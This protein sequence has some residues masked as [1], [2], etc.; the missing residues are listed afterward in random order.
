MCRRVTNSSDARSRR[1]NHH[2]VQHAD[3]HHDHHETGPCLRCAGPGIDDHDYRAMTTVRFGCLGDRRAIARTRRAGTKATIGPRCAQ[4]RCRWVTGPTA[5][6]NEGCVGWSVAEALGF[7][8]LSAQLR[9]IVLD[10]VGGLVAASVL[11]EKDGVLRR[12]G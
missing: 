11:D 6:N 1:G 10:S 5:C 4:S 8:A 9:T 3:R 7:A 2:H 12:E